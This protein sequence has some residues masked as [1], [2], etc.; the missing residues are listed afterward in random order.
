V[1][2]ETG[3]GKTLLA[4]ALMGMTPEGLSLSG[5]IA[6][7]GHVIDPGNEPAWR[8]VRA[9]RV[10]MIFQEPL[11]ALDPLRRIGDTIAEPL[12]VHRAMTRAAARARALELLDETGIPQATQRLD[13]YPHEL[14]GGQRQ[15]VLIALALACDPGLLIADEPTTA[16]DAAVALRITDLLVRLSRER[17]MALMFISHDLAAVSRAT[18]SLAVM[19]GGDIVERGPTARVL[20]DPAHPYTQGLLAARPSLAHRGRRRLPTIPGAV[21]P[22][23]ALPP[24]CRFAGR[25]GHELPRCAGT[26]PA[27][28]ATVTGG[29]AAC[30]L[31]DT[32]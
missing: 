9:R 2:G 18:A 17:D 1:V 20:S 11:S 12:I 19:Y 25:C 6:V 10:A 5:R 27:D 22:I 26:R 32:P 15:R 29:S 7:D 3:S 23:E 21:P 31:L 8:A 13:Q 28:T 4:L 14:S 16:L 30:H 24:G